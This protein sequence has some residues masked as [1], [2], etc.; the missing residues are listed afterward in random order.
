MCTGMC[1]WLMVGGCQ[2]DAK[3]EIVVPGI[4]RILTVVEGKGIAEK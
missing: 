1:L 3:E 2:R 4:D